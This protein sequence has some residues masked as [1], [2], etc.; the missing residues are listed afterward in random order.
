MTIEQALTQIKKELGAAG[1]KQAVKI[2]LAVQMHL[3]MKDEV[4]VECVH[5]KSRRSEHVHRLTVQVEPKSK[6]V[7]V[8]PSPMSPPPLDKP[9]SRQLKK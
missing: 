3:G 2:D 8:N 4:T 9:S 5:S 6:K 7:K 1:I